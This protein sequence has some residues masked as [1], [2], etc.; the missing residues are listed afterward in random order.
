VSAKVLLALLG[1]GCTVSAQPTLNLSE[2]LVKLG[3]ASQNMV[4]N[5]PSVDAGPLFFQG[6]LYAQNKKIGRVIADP[7]AYYFLSQ[8]Y[9]GTHLAW[10]NLSN[11]TLDL[12]GSDLHF[13]FP[14]ATGISLTN[15]T[16]I[17][18]QNFTVDYDPL[19][20]TQVQVLSVN[21]AQQQ[22]QFAV[23]GNWQ[24]PSVLNEV[25]SIPNGSV[26]VHIFRDGR[27]IIGANRLHAANPIGSSQFTVSPDPGLTPS[28][29]VA[30]IRPGDITV[31]CM[32]SSSVAVGAI[33]CTGCTVR[34]IAIYSGAG[35]GFEGAFAEFSV[36]DHIYVMP[37]PDT[38]RLV[39]SFTGL[40]L[41]G[42]LGNQIRQSRMIRTMDNGLEYGTRVIGS[43][44]SQTDNR[45]FVVEGLITSYVSYGLAVPNGSAVSFQRL[46]D[47][48]VVASAVTASP[49][50]PP[51]SGEPP[52]A[53]FTFDRDLP[54][55]IVG[56]LIFGT[57]PDSRAANSVVERNAVEEE[58]DCCS[59][60]FVVGLG[61]STFLG[62]YAQRTAMS[63]LQTENDL[64]PGNFNSPPSSN[65]GIS[66]NV[67][68]GANWTRTGYPLAQLGSISVD[69]TNAP[70]LLTGSPDQNISITGNFIAD[71]GSAAVWL[72]NTNGGSVSGNY[73]LNPNKNPAVESA[74]SF[75]GPSTLPLVTQSSQS[76][77]IGSNIVD[78]S[79]GRMW[80]TDAQYSELA[81][82][83]PGSTVR[84]N[85]YGLG[86]LVPAPSV[87]LTD[88]DGN[89]TPLSIQYATPHAIDVQLPASAGLGGAYLTAT[90]GGA[91][92][93]GT[94]FLDVVDN[95]PALNGC[96]Y[97]ISPS[98]VSVGAG[99][100]GL[101]ILVV[102]QAGCPYQVLDADAFVRQGA[103]GAGT[104]VVNVGFA[105]NTGAD[106]NTTIEITGEQFTVKQT[107][108]S[109]TVTSTKLLPQFAFGGGW[110]SALYF[111]MTGNGTASFP[112]SFFGNDGSPLSVPSV[113]G[114]TAVV[115]LAAWGTAI[116]EAPNVGGLKQGYVSVILPP[117]VTGYAVFRQ[118]VAGVPDQEAVVP[119]SDSSATAATLI[120]DDTAFTTSVAV[121]GLSSASSTVFVTAR[122]A[123]G[124]VIGT[125]TIVL[126]PNGK[127]ATPLRGVPGLAGIA[128]QRG[129]ADFSIS[130]GSVAVL[131]I[132]FGGAAFTDIPTATLSGQSASA[133]PT[134]AVLPQFA[135]GGGWYTAMYF[136][137]T[138]SGSALPFA[139]NFI[140]NDGNPLNVPALGG[141]SVMVN[142]APR[143]TALIEAPNMG[144]LTQGY[145]SAVLP[146]GVTGYAVFRQT[147][148]GKPDQEAVVPLSG[149]TSTNDTLIFDDTAFTTSMAVVGLSSASS[150]VFVTARDVGGNVIGT[151]TI[152]LP[153]NGKVAT[154]L[155][156]VP[157]LAGIAG[158]RGSANFSI[159][160][161][162][163]AVLGI[164]F[165]G[166]AF[167][168]IP[169]T[170]Q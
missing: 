52:Q 106:R 98:A 30:L 54:Q 155:R 109:N 100:G 9:A 3:I 33:R 17:A 114:S 63:G 79:S 64:Q 14:V 167:T 35:V 135:S 47:G 94:L 23:A 115:D 11:L 139:V 53:T 131:G 66:N 46:T 21:P 134:S 93:F 140:G 120:F 111:T 83:A 59:G 158:Q 147:V 50:A 108:L 159:A 40:Q 15:A 55:S 32:R 149:V 113:G 161:G 75:F 132:R 148:A 122:D 19:P 31:L 133:V 127:V 92:Y 27:P 157:G 118:T 48:A 101:P 170:A 86:S 136:T 166:S 41:S 49:V 71:S 62:N 95:I 82:Y 97:E 168:D 96:T 38:D 74:V 6:V 16:N 119:L 126:P 112:V 121:V 156:D 56:T 73:F 116:I 137:M 13:T 87:T 154:A 124:N 143:G 22:I 130:S 129:S 45:T 10:A 20:F 102:T 25:F 128:G 58:T 65:F 1:V 60:F 89:T 142:L 68:D 72:G 103:G 144:S 34:N 169:T 44:Q 163:V 107:S 85:T 84:L 61:N 81:A 146:P 99:A 18:L 80:V 7:G 125:G 117:G 151:G 12:Q 77:A 78:Q 90:S 145:V 2:D 105:V 141:S 39:S 91:K 26:D 67:I 57:D 76:I 42:G 36:F 160:P 37:K 29:V 164:R 88:A 162:D 51:Y 70:V 123:G 104:G 8:Q 69:A 150:T 165:G 24:N 4:P 43:V 110:Y 28:D 5:Q 152:A 153:P 138:G